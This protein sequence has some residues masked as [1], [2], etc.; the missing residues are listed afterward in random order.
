M[1]NKVS[2]IQRANPSQPRHQ[3]FW[4][5]LNNS[6]T[7]QFSESYSNKFKRL[8]PKHHLKPSDF[9]K[10]CSDGKT[11]LENIAEK[12]HS[13][14][15]KD[16]FDN[17]D[18]IDIDKKY[19]EGNTLLHIA[20][21]NGNSQMAE[22]LIKKGAR[23]EI[24]SDG[25]QI[26]LTLCP[27]E[28][29]EIIKL[30]QDTQKL[31]RDLHEAIKS[32]DKDKISEFLESGA[33]PNG[34][35]TQE[36]EEQTVSQGKV[37]KGKFVSNIRLAIE[38]NSPN[39]IMGLLMNKYVKTTSNPLEIACSS[40]KEN[41]FE[42]LNK[43]LSNDGAVSFE[44]NIPNLLNKS[45]QHGS[46]NMVKYLLNDYDINYK[47]ENEFNNNVLQ[48]AISNQFHF[49][50]DDEKARGEEIINLLID[51]I[52]EKYPQHE[53]ALSSKNTNGYDARFM[54]SHAGEIGKDL[55][56]TINKKI[57][58]EKQKE[59][60]RIKKQKEYADKI[61]KRDQELKEGGQ[62][63]S[64]PSCM[65]ALCCCMNNVNVERE[66]VV[67]NSQGVKADIVFE[68]K[69]FVPKIEAKMP[70]HET[71]EEQQPIL[72]PI[73]VQAPSNTNS[74]QKTNSQVVKADLLFKTTTP[75]EEVKSSNI[76]LMQKISEISTVSNDSP[77]D[78]PNSVEIT[79]T[80][81]PAVTP[82]KPS[83]GG[84]MPRAIETSSTMSV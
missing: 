84:G 56:N 5:Y 13:D 19:N 52:I 34:G 2:E 30:L 29:T 54:L 68:E 18:D 40:D 10:P 78:N 8:I 50:T 74:M 16:L 72:K 21:K 27:P 23:I 81:T 69:T 25:D 62:S 32:K 38:S 39:E 83:Q 65:T 58:K 33:R 24:L 61:Q 22:F 20:V 1:Q 26:P 31:D 17:Y 70:Q 49:K 44:K 36:V 77:R 71:F 55:L 75:Q 3:M 57:E 11:I 80:S 64:N 79:L 46:V 73:E 66:D 37:R 82:S 63:D 51:K 14:I 67:G 48:V 45:I 76:N 43:Y 15:I 42:Y 59:D 28:N 47:Y 6:N 9:M 4:D 12:G 35:I 41:L 53:E 60:E 7:T